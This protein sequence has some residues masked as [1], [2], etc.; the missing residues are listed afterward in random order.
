LGVGFLVRAN[1]GRAIGRLSGL[2][3]WRWRAQAV[4]QRRRRWAGWKYKRAFHAAGGKAKGQQGY[5]YSAH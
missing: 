1:I 4:E 2:G 5:D 3:W